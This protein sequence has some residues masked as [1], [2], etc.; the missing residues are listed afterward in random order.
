MTTR[1]IGAGLQPILVTLSIRSFTVTKDIMAVIPVAVWITIVPVR[2]S[3]T[4]TEPWANKHATAEPATV[5][6]ATVEPTTVEPTTVEPTTVESASVEPAS[7]EPATTVASSL[8]LDSA[9]G[10][11]CYAE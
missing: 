6:P 8:C 3:V 2:I 4:V 5:E 7:V 11:Y 10:D 9:A 1:I